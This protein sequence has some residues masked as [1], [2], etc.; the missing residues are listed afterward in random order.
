MTALWHRKLYG[1]WIAARCVALR[2]SALPPAVMLFDQRRNVYHAVLAVSVPGN[3]FILDN[4][5]NVVMTDRQ[6]PD[7]MPLY[8]LVDGRGYFHGMKVKAGRQIAAKTKPVDLV[9][10]G[11]GPETPE[12]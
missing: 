8:S 7:Y 9:A 5:R 11:E 3:Y 10:P 4:V 2:V 1:S 6:L 12:L